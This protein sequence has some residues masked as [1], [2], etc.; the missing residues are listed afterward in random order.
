MVNEW[1]VSGKWF[2]VSQSVFPQV[3][4]GKCDFLF[5]KLKS[6]Q[7]SAISVFDG[8][9]VTTQRPGFGLSPSVG[10]LVACVDQGTST[11]DSFRANQDIF[12]RSKNFKIKQKIILKNN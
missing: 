6:I 12:F 1:M 8:Q 11:H 9:F 5:K 4:G 3:G 10:V 7:N 2:V